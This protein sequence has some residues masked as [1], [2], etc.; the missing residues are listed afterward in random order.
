MRRAPAGM[1]VLAAGPAAV[2]RPSTAMTT[3]SAMTRPATTSIMRAPVMAMVSAVAGM[4]E[5][6]ASAAMDG[7]KILRMEPPV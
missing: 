4:A 1:A 6:R 2:M 5:Q 7:L 3:G